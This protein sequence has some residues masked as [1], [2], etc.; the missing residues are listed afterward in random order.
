MAK[1]GK[2]KWTICAIVYIIWT[3]NVKFVFDGL[4]RNLPHQH[5]PVGIGTRTFHGLTK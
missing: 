2:I 4:F 1:A 5:N 3:A